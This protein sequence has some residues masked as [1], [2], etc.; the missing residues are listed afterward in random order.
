MAYIKSPRRTTTIVHRRARSLDWGKLQGGCGRAWETLSDA[1][2]ASVNH[3]FEG[4][5][6]GEMM[7]S[8]QSKL[9]N[10]SLPTTRQ[11]ET[12]IDNLSD[13]IGFLL[14][15]F[16]AKTDL[17]GTDLEGAQWQFAWEMSKKARK[18]FVTQGICRR[19]QTM[20]T[21]DNLNWQTKLNQCLAN[22]YA[23]LRADYTAG[24]LCRMKPVWS[25]DHRRNIWRLVLETGMRE[26]VVHGNNV[27]EAA[28]YLETGFEIPG[29]GG[30][31]SIHDFT[32]GTVGFENGEWEMISEAGLVAGKYAISKSI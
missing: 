15:R 23:Q 32:L 18:A 8:I 24:V 25:G 14:D 4:K 27:V 13:R 31:T 2:V 6:V 3:A 1:A 10:F 9:P 22:T 20:P 26:I 7:D 28:E 29:Q 21:R 30:W 12:T 19:W 16:P 5:D 11:F 17:A